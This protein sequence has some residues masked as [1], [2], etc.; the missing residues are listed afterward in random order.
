MKLTVRRAGTLETKPLMN[1]NRRKSSGAPRDASC[2]A[3][4]KNPDVN[5]S[6][7]N[8]PEVYAYGGI[9]MELQRKMRAWFDPRIAPYNSVEEQW[10]S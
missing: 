7:L 3:R 9:K 4:H 5:R 6:P 10:K 2:L 8:D 1:A